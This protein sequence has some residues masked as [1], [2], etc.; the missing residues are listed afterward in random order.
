M[1]ELHGKKYRIL[2]NDL[3]ICCSENPSAHAIEA[4]R[5]SGE[6]RCAKSPHAVA[7]PFNYNPKGSVYHQPHAG[8]ALK[9]LAGALGG[10]TIAR[11]KP[12]APEGAPT[13]TTAA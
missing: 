5:D 1:A 12:R 4:D 10:K 11:L 13:L 3:S 7:W 8:R 2:E 9:C 6:A